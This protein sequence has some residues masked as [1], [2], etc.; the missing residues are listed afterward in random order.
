MHGIHSFL[1]SLFR[2]AAGRSELPVKLTRSHRTEQQGLAKAFAAVLFI[3]QKRIS[4]IIGWCGN[5]I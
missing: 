4:L 5:G 1:R 3:K 2:Q